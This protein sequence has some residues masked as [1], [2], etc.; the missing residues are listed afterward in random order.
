M[1]IKLLSLNLACGLCSILLALVDFRLI[2]STNVMFKSWISTVILRPYRGLGS[3]IK[4]TKMIITHSILTHRINPVFYKMN[5]IIRKQPDCRGRTNHMRPV[6]MSLPQTFT[7]WNTQGC[8]NEDNHPCRGEQQ[9]REKRGTQNQLLPY[10]HPNPSCLPFKK[11]N[12]VPF[13]LNCPQEDICLGAIK[14]LSRQ[15]TKQMMRF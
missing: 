7:W 6:E 14:S 11:I 5:I 3:K 2:S 13:S 4:H 10:K 15:K 12:Y 9:D 8:F 1:A